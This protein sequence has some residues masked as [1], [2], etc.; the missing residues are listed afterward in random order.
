[1]T[2][3]AAWPELHD[4]ATDRNEGEWCMEKKDDEPRRGVRDRKNK[5][6]YIHEVI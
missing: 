1:L 6:G 3:A 5:D 2:A 4:C